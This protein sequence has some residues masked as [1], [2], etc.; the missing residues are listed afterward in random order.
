MG[1][2]RYMS[3]P[4]ESPPQHRWDLTHLLPYRVILPLDSDFYICLTPDFI[5]LETLDFYLF[6]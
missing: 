4:L 3:I 2:K 5:L 6:K 1:C